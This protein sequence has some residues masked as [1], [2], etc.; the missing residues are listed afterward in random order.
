MMRNHSNVCNTSN[1]WD[2]TNIHR[3]CHHHTQK[4]IFLDQQSHCF[5]K[6]HKITL[7]RGPNWHRDNESGNAESI[8]EFLSRSIA[9]CEVRCRIG[10]AIDNHGSNLY[11]PGKSSIQDSEITRPE[12]VVCHITLSEVVRTLSASYKN[13][14]MLTLGSLGVGISLIFCWMN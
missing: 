5:R 8:N 2:W 1:H 7:R 14:M 9:N 6:Y 13:D 11:Y 3:E 10:G 12:T 4:A